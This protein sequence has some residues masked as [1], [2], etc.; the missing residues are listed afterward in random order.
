MNDAND[1]RLTPD[2]RAEWERIRKR[3]QPRF[4]FVIVCWAALTIS[5]GLTFLTITGSLTLVNCPT[6]LQGAILTFLMF[7]VVT[8]PLSIP[9][10]FLFGVILWTHKE[11]QYEA[12]LEYHPTEGELRERRAKYR[13]QLWFAVP[14]FASFGLAALF[15]DEVGLAPIFVIGG[16]LLL[17]IACL[18]VK[19]G[20]WRH[21]RRLVP[22]DHWQVKLKIIVYVVVGLFGIG[23]G[24]M[25]IYDY[26]M[27][28][29]AGW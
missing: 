11:Y 26:L 16:V 4:V 28:I 25:I 20:G 19:A 9:A 14:L 27:L 10:G 18:A 6:D 3:G 5:G 15:F 12:S 7:L 23:M 8:L 24:S 17:G 1:E 2:E 22:I 21:G 13:S 29:S